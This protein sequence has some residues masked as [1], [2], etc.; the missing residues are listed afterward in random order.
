[1]WWTV[2]SACQEPFDTD[3]H[4]LVGFR[5]AAVSVA[6]DTPADVV[7]PRAA[8]IVDG[9]PWAEDPVELAWYRVDAPG[10][11]ALLDPLSPAAAVGPEPELALSEEAAFLGLVAR[12]GDREDRA[13]IEIFPSAPTFDGPAGFAVEAL[14][15]AV[16]ELE[17][18]ELLLEARRSLVPEPSD[19]V[20]PG[21][22]VRI[23]A[24][25]EGDPLVHW[26]AT[27][28][29]FFELDR[30]TTD[31]AA[32]DLRL[33]DEEIDDGRSTLE[34]GWVTVVGLALGEPGETRF[35]A[36]DLAVGDPGPGI[37]TG[38]RFVP[39]DAPVSWTD[40]TVVRGTLVADDASPIGLRLTETT[41]EPTPVEDYGTSRLSC[42]VPRNGP[43]DPAWLLNPGTVYPLTYL[44]VA[45]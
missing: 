18:P 44:P 16:P 22:F 28:G 31:W 19:A 23:T 42:L 2:W 4:D 26:M 7:R 17:G 1:M 41:V 10:D 40:G 14:P 5:I 11:V 9:R 34:A 45:A 3:R 20:D 35:G 38:G 37:W 32:G 33:D 30:H 43:F 13:F 27:A 21:G 6:V 29:T 8:V 24:S 12:S 25:V 39:T 15:L 36:T